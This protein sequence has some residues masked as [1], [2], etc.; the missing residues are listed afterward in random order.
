MSD[1]IEQRLAAAAQA[2]RELEITRR[3]CADL[4]ARQDQLGT[5]LA[6]LQS[7]YQLEQKDVGKLEHL[8]LSR[9]LV[10][11]R[12]S[13][14]EALARE[15]AEAHAVQLRLADAQARLDAVRG[16]HQAALAQANRLS[17][18]PNDYAALLTE[19]ERHLT[20]SSD[21]RRATLLSLADERGRLTAELGE[22]Q[23][24]MQAADAA[25]Q[26]LSLVEDKLGSASSWNTYDTFFG[27]GMLATAMEH[28]R[29][30]DAAQAAAEADRRMAVLRTDLTQLDQVEATSPMITL[31][32]ATRFMDLWFNNI[33]TDLAVRDR[34][35]QGQQNV[36]QSLQMVSAVEERLKAQSADVQSRLT[37]IEGQR[38]DLLTAS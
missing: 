15:Q 28:S 33:F 38:R 3:R 32:S 20:E 30:D 36:A 19:K 29:L 12:G 8:S 5:E 34:I 1:D 37:E 22:M 9:V 26:A 14:E 25:R 27:G 7:Q 11:L 13:H 16:E 18:A 17:S 31:S 2:A 23:A 21:P 6:A 4:Q 24:A 10:T 35:N